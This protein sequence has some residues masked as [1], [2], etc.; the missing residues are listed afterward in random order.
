MSDDQQRKASIEDQFRNCDEGADEKGF[1]PLQEHTYMDEGKTGTTMF[2]RPGFAALRAAYT[3]E[4][5]PFKVI[6]IDD[7]SRMGRN[8]ADVFKVLDEL[9]FY[10][11]RIYFASDG[12]DSINPW[13][14][15][16]F[17]AKAR[18]DAQWSKTHGKRVSRGRI[19]LFDRGLNPGWSCYGY[20]NAPVKSDDPN[21]R[22]RAALKGWEEKIDPEKARIVVLIFTWYAAGMS[23]RQ[24]TV[25]LNEEGVPPPRKTGRKTKSCT[26]ARSAVAYILRNERY[27]GICTYGRTTQV[28]NPK[29]GKMVQRI[30]P[31][32]EWL[33]R[34]HPEL[35]IVDPE[36]WDKVVAERTRKTTVGNTNI[37]GMDRT[38]NSRKYFL[39]SLLECGCGAKY[40]LRAHGR[41]VCSGYLW[42]NS[43]S[44]CA[45]F[46]REEIEAALISALCDQLRS[47]DLREPLVQSLFERLKSEKARQEGMVDQLAG[48][49]AQLEAELKAEEGCRDNLL[50]AIKIGGDLRPLVEELAGAQAHIDRI[51]GM[52][53]ALGKPA[54][55]KSVRIG[56]VR[57]FVEKHTGAFESL[58]MGS[59]E[60]LKVEFQRRVSPAL[61]VTPV[62]TP[63]GHVYRVSG[64]VA[65]FSPDDGALLYKPGNPTVQQNT[66]QVNFDIPLYVPKI[67]IHTAA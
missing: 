64:D 59:A 63:K 28:R 26:W 20:Y 35:R 17:A 45:T 29:T 10:G 34:E 12:L 60:T 21:A 32:S 5:S 47:P 9:D 37:G 1:N 43:C 54:E 49:K 42:R 27:L 23:L 56:E 3:Q 14:R 52:L 50:E 41:Y 51:G 57:K 40:H 44:N 61:K 16:A 38:E 46:K 11:I 65:L 39:S 8:E 62:E 58:L 48:R 15:D 31:K 36:L 6:I 24:I 19:G 2:G 25:R 53:S 30:H 66:I 18:Q 33:K 67:R 55:V 4:N 13:F 7:T 22:G